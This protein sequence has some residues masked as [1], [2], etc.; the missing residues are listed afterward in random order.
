MLHSSYINQNLSLGGD[1]YSSARG[2]IRTGQIQRSRIQEINAFRNLCQ[3]DSF[4][5]YDPG[6]QQDAVYLHWDIFRT[7]G[8]GLVSKQEHIRGSE[9][10]GC[11]RRNLCV[12]LDKNSLCRFRVLL[13]CVFEYC[14]SIIGRDDAVMLRNV[15]QP[16]ERVEIYGID[17]FSALDKMKRCINMCAI[18]CAHAKSRQVIWVTFFH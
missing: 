2:T 5:Q 4:K 3:T 11:F 8:L 1:Q 10:L 15:S 6:S 7:N 17:G 12:S 13:F 9:Y 16:Y 14:R 18:M